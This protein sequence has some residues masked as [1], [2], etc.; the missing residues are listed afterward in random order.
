MRSYNP[1]DFSSGD[2]FMQSD[3][4]AA[5]PFAESDRAARE[6]E[7]PEGVLDYAPTDPDVLAACKAARVAQ[8]LYEDDIGLQY[9]VS[10]E[11]IHRWEQGEWTLP[12]GTVK[13]ICHDLGVAVPQESAEK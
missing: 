10:A 9:A 4:E 8:G 5:D 3:I 12:P 1:D 6:A 7:I 13:S 11:W 2:D